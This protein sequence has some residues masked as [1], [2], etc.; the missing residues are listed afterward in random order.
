MEVDY[1]R[2]VAS[3]T[4]TGESLQR[5]NPEGVAINKAGGSGEGRSRATVWAV[6]A[7]LIAAGLSVFG[8]AVS[9]AHIRVDGDKQFARAGYCSVP[10]NTAADESALQPGTFLN[11]TVGEPATNRHYTGALPANFIEGIGLTCAGA[12]A[13]YVRHGFAADADHV[14][15]GIYPYYLPGRP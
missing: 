11:L 12:P 15:T 10:G 9:R 1:E 7:A 14:G 5:E 2:M 13:G 3:S 6:V 8:L 4:T